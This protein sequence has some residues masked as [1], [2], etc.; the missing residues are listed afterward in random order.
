M[1]DRSWRTTGLS[2]EA[3]LRKDFWDTINNKNKVSINLL[4]DTECLERI[5]AAKLSKE[6]VQLHPTAAGRL[7]F[8]QEYNVAGQTA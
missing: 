4:T 6:D 2:D 3:K 8:G 5:G 7:M 1:Y